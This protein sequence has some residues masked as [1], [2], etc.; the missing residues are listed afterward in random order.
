VQHKFNTDKKQDKQTRK[1]EHIPRIE[2]II[3]SKEHEMTAR[4]TAK[5]DMSKAHTHAQLIIDTRNS[6]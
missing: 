4:V 5:Y 1:V 6:S 2:M 3:S